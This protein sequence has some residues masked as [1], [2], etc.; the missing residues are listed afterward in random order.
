MEERAPPTHF[1]AVQA[2]AIERWRNLERDPELAGPWWQLFR[3]IQSPRHVLSELLQNADDAGAES[4][5]AE[6]RGGVFMFTH[7]GRDFDAPSLRSL[8]RF[9]SSNKRTL[10]TI[11]F[12]GMGFKSAFS[13]GPRVEV[14]TPSLS[15]AFKRARFSEPIWI[16]DHDPESPLTS[17][18]IPLRD[19]GILKVVQSEM[20]RWISDPVSI[21]FFRNLRTLE[22]NGITVERS[23]I[24]P[25]P[26][27]NSTRIKVRSRHDYEFTLISSEERD[28]PDMAWEEI[29]DERRLL[30]DLDERVPARVQLILG[31]SESRL[32]VVLPTEA[33]LTTPFSVN[34]PF[35]QDP[36]RVRIK[37]P[38]QS[39]TNQWLLKEAGS[40]AA[41]AMV[42]WTQRRSLGPK[43][44]VEA[45]CDLLPRKPATEARSATDDI[46]GVLVDA[47]ADGL[48][49]Q[50]FIVDADE[51]PRNPTG[52]VALDDRLFEVW[53]A[54]VLRGVWV[55]SDGSLL[56]PGVSR[57][58]RRRLER[59]G[60]LRQVSAEEVLE[61]LAER[62]LVRPDGRHGLVSLWAYVH[63][64]LPDPRSS[65]KRGPVREGLIRLRIVPVS[66]DSELHPA[67]SLLWPSGGSEFSDSD[68]GFL[69]SIVPAVDPNWL[70]W[71]EEL[72]AEQANYP[73]AGGAAIALAERL[74]REARTGAGE[75]LE[76]VSRR[77]FAGEG[78]NELDAGIRLAFLMARTSLS[79]PGNFQ[80]L[81]EDG[82]WRG[83]RH[84]ILGDPDPAVSLLPERLLT[85]HLL[86]SRYDS[87]V[88]PAERQRWLRWKRSHESGLR[89]FLLPGSMQESVFGRSGLHEAL[90]RRGGEPPDETPIQRE[91]FKIQ[92]WDFAGD[93]WEHWEKLSKSNDSLWCDLTKAMALDWDGKWKKRANLTVRQRGYSREHTVSTGGAMS[94]WVH[95]LRS[96]PCLPDERG[97]P[98]VPAELLR[99]N[100]RTA[101][102]RG[103][104]RALSP[105]LDV[106][107]ND[108]LLSLLGVRERADNAD[109]LL[110]RLRA[111]SGSD[112]PEAP[113]GRLY[114][115]ID[116][117]IP[118][119]PR[120]QREVVQTAFRDHLIIR[121]S[122]GRWYGSQQVFQANPLGIPALPVVPAVLSGL[123]LWDAVG[124]PKEVDGDTAL[125][126]VGAIEPGTVLSQE[127]VTPVR[128]ILARFPVEV[129]SELRR[130]LA[131]DGSWRKADE[132]AYYS[133]RPESLATLFPHHQRKIADVSMVPSEQVGSI[134]WDGARP[135]RQVLEIRP[136]QA[137]AGKPI[138]AGWMNVLGPLITR[139]P[140]LPDETPDTYRR[141][142]R[143]ASELRTGRIRL[144]EELT[145][146]P[147]I[148]RAPAGPALGARAIWHD[149]ELYCADTGPAIHS[150]LVRAL[151]NR[152]TS[153][154]I[155]EAIGACVDRD[156]FWIEEYF[157]HHFELLPDPED[158]PQPTEETSEIPAGESG[159]GSSTTGDAD[160][161]TDD[162]GDPAETP[163]EAPDDEGLEGDPGRSEPEAIPGGEPE[164]G[165]PVRPSRPPAT[166]LAAPEVRHFQ[167]KG[168]RPIPGPSSPR[169]VHEESGDLLERES[170]WW[171]RRTSRGDLVRRYLPTR[172]SLS[173]G[174]E[175]SHLAY[176]QLLEGSV[177]ASLLVVDDGV[178][179]V[180]E[181]SSEELR[182]LQDTGR[183]KVFP[184][185]YRLRVDPDGRGQS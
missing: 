83:P 108:Q 72:D 155:R 88:A 36:A 105:D 183:L 160:L 116:R 158:S 70:G 44:R 182:E 81:C 1:E 178:L 150:D 3:Q 162:P 145:G 54:E 163:R 139:I 126:F 85:Q 91:H 19:E 140:Q 51:S 104:E 99:M 112:A 31:S 39:P 156:P 131:G 80:F 132:F 119:L 28:L 86:S 22:L 5:R 136:V 114:E 35:I 118:E 33:E 102:L 20:E 152:V 26:T 12:R 59:W 52:S 111:L 101:H 113:L 173:R 87:S 123:A 47:F 29:R 84:T 115:T 148:E 48:E 166:P 93:L 142:A 77:I 89:R 9:G 165:H 23:P 130:W 175:L 154:R 125:G 74:R 137:V 129:W 2:E 60:F 122:D 177:P 94:S 71:L 6:V 103:V 65:W 143:F 90:R 76:R 18:R 79:P 157:A 179:G 30:G 138:E 124:V 66:G 14:R 172:G 55:P 110:D 13:L 97:V 171:L 106:P 63:E 68:W 144:V 176:S 46:V 58:S 8:C 135:L 11:G 82:V 4:A 15:F 56:T 53:P 121:A 117:S 146:T 34:A 49:G 16:G 17:I 98:T 69:S 134:P 50:R 133:R 24:G 181:L 170:G 149:G 27:E 73:S 40:L 159:Q 168:F 78:S 67:R 41:Q 184:H 21:L 147:Y 43:A 180:R 7:D 174:I 120:E 62:S 61:I 151:G 164:G 161:G 185:T 10:A 167:R 95:K 25:G 109:V 141:R 127:R 96:L 100:P 42:A 32:Y 45:Y 107:E 75:V 64:S 37:P 38:S 57:D 153:S 128:E 169:L 92:D